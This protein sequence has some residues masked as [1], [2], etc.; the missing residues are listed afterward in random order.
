MGRCSWWWA[1]VELSGLVARLGNSR[2]VEEAGI[3][4]CF[5]SLQRPL[6][7]VVLGRPLTAA[8]TEKSPGCS[9]RWTAGDFI[10]KHGTRVNAP[11]KALHSEGLVA[12]LCRA[13]ACY[14]LGLASY[15]FKTGAI[16]SLSAQLRA[17]VPGIRVRAGCHRESPSWGAPAAARGRRAHG[18]R[19]AAQRSP[20][21]RT[22]Y[23]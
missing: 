2:L 21:R 19:Y 11:T 14:C 17:R 6:A 16:R 18:Y 8:D 23:Q 1:T 7:P 13:T 20:L 5:G 9:R 12:V 4:G 10:Q 15:H 3:H 22:M